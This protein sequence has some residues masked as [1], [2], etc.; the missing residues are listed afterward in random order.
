MLT[1]VGASTERDAVLAELA[2][3]AHDP[4][5]RGFTFQQAELS[6]AGELTPWL[7]AK[8]FLV[9]AIEPAS[10]ET[11][12][13]L[14][15]A[16]LSTPDVRSGLQVRAGTFLTEFGLINPAHPHAWQWLN[17]PVMHT[18]VFG[19]DGMR[20][21]GLRVAASGRLG[22]LLF[23]AQNASGETM[24]SFLA[25]AEVYDERAIG[26]RAFVARDVR[27]LG[28]V[29]YT[30]RAACT[31]A[32]DHE[33]TLVLG[34]STSLGPNATGEH[35]HTWLYGVDLRWL[36]PRPG[37]EDGFEVPAWLLQAEGIGRA[38]AASG[39]VDGADPLAPVVVPRSTLRDH[40]GYVQALAGCSATIAVGLRVEFA[41]GSGGSYR[42]NGEFAR[43]QD[44]FRA[45]RLRVS[46]LC[47]WQPSHATSVR[48]QY[49]FDDSDHLASSS[50]S[51]WLGFEVLL[52][53]HA[54]H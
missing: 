19:G 51:L 49:D 54:A 39:Q 38:F 18:R 2:G 45:D 17:Q 11:I 35:A 16:F 21:P 26:G 31:L 42:G 44:A 6:F 32:A 37:H 5:Q 33:P 30:L 13:E 43:S 28:D 12:V 9:A 7:A 20:G 14:E 15:E 25:N 52:G 3:G 24:P 50:H 22:Q 1:A 29:V 4:R 8:A 23:A 34:A 36:V 27:S 47:S 40:G 41:G 10:G 53:A 46:P 48:L